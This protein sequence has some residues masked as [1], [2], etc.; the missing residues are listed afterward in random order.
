MKNVTNISSLE[1]DLNLQT[2]CKR[3]E[4]R[5]TQQIPSHSGIV[6][7]ELV[8]NVAKAGWASRSATNYLLNS[9]SFFLGI[10]RKENEERW[11][12][13]YSKMIRY[14][15]QYYLLEDTIPNSP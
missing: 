10:A 13:Y 1:W 9:T 8:D 11:R 3:K 12:R 5:K 6:G 4:Q 15:T 2:P 7:N 14:S